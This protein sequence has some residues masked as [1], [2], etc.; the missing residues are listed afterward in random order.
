VRGQTEDM[1]EFHVHQFGPDDGEPVLA[2]HG[3]TG[4]GSRFEDLATRGPS[5]R[6]VLAPDLRGHGHS[7]C[8]P[9]WTV[10]QHVEDLIGALDAFSVERADVVGH[11]FGGCI[12]LHLLAA[13]PHRVRRL[14]LLDP[15]IALS[16]QTALPM[17]EL[18]LNDAS[19][20][21][22]EELQAA[23]RVGRSA[24]AVP[25]SDADAADA[26]FVGDDGRWRL[27][28]HRGAAV[29]A[30]SEMTREVPLIPVARPTLLVIA[31]D[32]DFVSEDQISALSDQLGDD[33]TV[34]RMDAG[35][36]LYWDDPE[37]TAQLV[38]KFLE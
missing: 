18:L 30:W 17:A 9:P 24:S 28:F 37:T 5:D 15:A 36:M 38:G 20:A 10:E 4:H 26:S 25:F 12:A 11:S 22:L 7:S 35:H 14:V 13:A 33:L 2:I 29:A 34:A 16:P 19:Y 1:S 32:A 6:M 8:Q 31:N 21:S 27:R 23:R 3:V